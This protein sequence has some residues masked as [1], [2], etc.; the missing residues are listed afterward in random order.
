MYKTK[1]AELKVPEHHHAIPREIVRANIEAK[2]R[3]KE[4][5]LNL[6][7]MFLQKTVAVKEFSRED[8]LHTVAEFIVCDDQV[9]DSRLACVVE[10]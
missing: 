4:G 2:K 10:N 6:G 5:Q 3:A 1:C 8:V 9:S 7:G